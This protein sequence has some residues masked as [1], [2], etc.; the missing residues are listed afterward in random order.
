MTEGFQLESAGPAAYERYLV[1]TF[2]APCAGELLATAPPR[3]GERVLDLACGTGIVAR[4]ASAFAGVGQVIGVDV[5]P[6]MISVARDVPQDPVG[7]IEWRTSDAHHIPLEADN[8]DL[9]CCQ[10]G[11]QFFSDPAAVI[12]ELRRVVAPGGRLL[13]AVWRQLEHNPAFGVL[14]DVLERQ[15]GHPAAD[16]MRAPFRGPSPDELRDWLTN[17]G[18]P[19]VSLRI[20]AYLVR[21][22]SVEEFLRQEAA[23]SPLAGPLGDANATSLTSLIADLEE[24]MEHFVDDQGVALPMQTWLILAHD[25]AADEPA[26]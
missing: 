14:S 19:V 18:F 23:G 7:Q 5:N 9:A 6:A 10:Q 3:P 8:I 11:L 2:F 22:P 24:S 12:R 16:M 21:F 1:P 15:V 13:L 20:A 26:R 17:G 4:R 25:G